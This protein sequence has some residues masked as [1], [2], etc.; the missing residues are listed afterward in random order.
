M[1]QHF[2]NRFVSVM[3]ATTVVMSMSVAFPSAQ[4]SETE[5]IKEAEKF[6][7][8]GADT[9]STVGKARLQ[10]QNTL[11]AYN[12]LVTQPSKDMKGDFKKLLNGAKDTG[13][14]VD[15]ARERVT[16]M[17]A[18]GDTYFAGRAAAIKEI[19]NADLREKGQQRL[20]KNKQEYG[21]VMASLAEAGQSLQTMRTDLDNQITYLGSDLT[22]SAMTS[23]KPETQKLN[24]RGVQVLAKA[25]QAITTANKY[26]NSLRPTKS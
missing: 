16:K 5:G 1:H 11:A 6:V 20:D 24:E 12:S 26:F 17:E 14:R 25:D 8:A 21:G 23:L 13:Q 10:V 2:V 9:A 15:E 3:A 19:Q 7:D 18:A 22:P 4:R